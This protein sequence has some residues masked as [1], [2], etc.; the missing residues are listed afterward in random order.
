MTQK[1]AFTGAEKDT[2]GLF[3]EADGG[4]IFLDE[5]GDISPYTQQSLLRV[6]Q[7]DVILPVG[8]KEQ[9][10]NVRIIAATHQ[11]LIEKCKQGE[12]RWDLYYRLSIVELKL[13][14]LRERSKR[15]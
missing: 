2:K 9:K 10:I 5:I 4:I 14:T 3:K 8:G 7:E 1:G 13:P 12:F 15:Y 11:N 6:I